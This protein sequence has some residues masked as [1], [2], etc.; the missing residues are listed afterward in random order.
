MQNYRES[1]RALA[2]IIKQV[3]ELRSD[4]Q[5]DEYGVLRAT[6]HACKRSCQLLA[7][8][9]TLSARDGQ[10]IP[11][12]CAST[13]SEGGVRID[14]MRPSA[15]VC[16]MVPASA[17]RAASVYHEVSGECSTEPATPEALARWLRGIS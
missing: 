17:T 8:A 11:R 15:A 16:L 6:E 12:G 7:D 14:W 9:A 3:V 5:T 2:G 4:D 10:P 1:Y 13:D